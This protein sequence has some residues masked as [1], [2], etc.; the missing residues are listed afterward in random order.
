MT[1]THQ[2]SGTDLLRTVR[3]N[4][5][6]YRAT[7]EPADHTVAVLRF[8]PAETDPPQWARRMEAS[9]ISAEQKVR[10][11][12]HLGYTVDHRVLP[13]TTPEAE[14]ARTIQALNVDPAVRAVI[15]QFPPP[16]RLTPFVQWLEP[17]KDIDA[18]LEDRSPYPAC[19]TAEGI[20]RV[21][22]PFARDADIAVVGARGFVGRGVV[23]LLEAHGFNVTPLDL[24]DDLR[25]AAEADIVV[26]T[27]GQP[28]LLTPEHIRPHHRLVVDSGFT[29]LSGGGVAG[30][31]HPAAATIPQNLTPVPGGIGPVE[32][33]VL[34]DRIVRQ[35]AAPALKPWSFPP[36]P[37]LTR[38][39]YAAGLAS[40]STP[41]PPSPTQSPRPSVQPPQQHRR[42]QGPN[43]SRSR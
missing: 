21:V 39:Q 32:M 37:Y 8:T 20:S 25:R 18:L 10:A 14:F 12:T 35:E 36:T 1:A 6:P 16:A 2:L 33:A 19:A 13:G 42:D 26:S 17:A 11:F 30:D 22:A 5:A 23:R 28:H 4:L 3:E 34:M 24:G 15:V 38:R 40:P 31:I 43:S 7:I 41:T 27:A 9:R 29:P